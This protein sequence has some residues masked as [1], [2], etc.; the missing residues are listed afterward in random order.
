M[1]KLLPFRKTYQLVRLMQW[2]EGKVQN[3]S[4]FNLQ[5]KKMK[6]ILLEVLE[7]GMATVIVE[8]KELITKN[9]KSH[10]K[11]EVAKILNFS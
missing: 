3:Y 8:V 6:F 10:K 1:N 7:V 11:E 9:Q 2:V 5:K 4:V